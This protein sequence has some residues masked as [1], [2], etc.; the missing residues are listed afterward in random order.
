VLWNAFPW[1]PYKQK[2]GLLTNRTP[3]DEELAAGH[4]MLHRMIA[5]GKFSQVVAVGKKSAAQMTDLGIDATEVR[6]PANGGAGLFR[7]QM[8]ELITR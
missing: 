6:H 5:L 2:E 7:R 8:T 1:H 4:L 3:T